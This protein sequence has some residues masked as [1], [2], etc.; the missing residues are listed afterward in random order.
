MAR[1]NKYL[2]LFWL[3]ALFSLISC[4]DGIENPSING[5]DGLCYTKP[6]GGHA[7]I[8]VNNIAG[9]NLRNISN[10]PGD[11]D[12]SQWSPD[13]NYILYSRRL[14]T[15]N[16]AVM[17]Y[18]TRDHINYQLTPDS[19]LAGLRPQWTPNGKIYFSYRT[20]YLGQY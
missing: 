9:T 4:K 6:Y 10:Y 2:E 1:Y 17:V 11:D 15:N 5:D 13:G 20:S 14:P 18:N 3:I 12:Y 16:I 19:G 7:E 8:F